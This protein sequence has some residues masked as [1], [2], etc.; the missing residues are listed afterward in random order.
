M[1]AMSF[2][3]CRKKKREE[4]MGDCD[5]IIN[6]AGNVTFNPPLESA[7]RT[8]VV[9]TNNVLKWRAYETSGGRSRFDVFCGGKA[10]RHDLGKRAGRR[11]FSAKEELIG[12][13]FRCRQ[14]SRRLR[15][16]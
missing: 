5:I 10:E 16:P 3:E 8:N 11:L 2:W 15:S 6:S 12:T 14:G 9:G 4:I 13:T 1:S 7:L